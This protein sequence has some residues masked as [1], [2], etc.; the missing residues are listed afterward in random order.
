MEG[1]RIGV[2][3]GHKRFDGGPKLIFA[4]KTGAAQRFARQQSEPDFHLV[5]PTGGG[6]REMELD[7][8][9]IFGK[10]I[11]ILFMR[12]VVIQNHVDFFA[13]R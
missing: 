6:W 12:T 13:D 1:L 2:G 9:L 7:S 4:G 3:L 10:P 5:E 8:S 11:R